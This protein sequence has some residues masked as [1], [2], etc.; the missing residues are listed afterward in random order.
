MLETN[1]NVFNNFQN[2]LLSSNKDI[3]DAKLIALEC[4]KKS[5][6]TGTPSEV[7]NEYNRI[8]NSILENINNN[9]KKVNFQTV[10]DN[11][12]ICLEDGKKMKMLKRHLRT[13]YKM[14]FSDYKEKW[15]LPY[16]Y[17]YVCKNYSKVRES[18]AR[19]RGKKK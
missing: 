10:F 6:F 18:I 14:S 15:G 5:N 13:K 11:Y 7:M 17:P 4:L 1:N 8:Y 3:N 19:K 2:G 16:D 12:I 9:G